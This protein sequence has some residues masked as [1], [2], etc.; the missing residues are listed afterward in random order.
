MMQG[1]GGLGKIVALGHAPHSRTTLLLLPVTQVPN[2]LDDCVALQKEK[3][4]GEGRGKVAWRMLIPIPPP[5]PHFFFLLTVTG[6]CLSGSPPCVYDS[7]RKIA[8]G[9][10]MQP[11]SILF[12]KNNS[13]LPTKKKE[14]LFSF[15]SIYVT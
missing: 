5:P 9:L 6:S 1:V 8:F 15:H 2:L 4:N 11:T 12:T 7:A 10:S 3:K 14:V 13:N